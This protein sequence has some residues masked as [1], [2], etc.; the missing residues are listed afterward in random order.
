TEALI[1]DLPE[2]E[3]AM[4]AMPHGGGG[5]GGMGGGDFQ[6]GRPAPRQ[7]GGLRG[8]SPRR[9]SGVNACH[10]R[11]GRARPSVEPAGRSMRDS[12]DVR[13]DLLGG[14]L[15]V[16][17]LLEQE[18]EDDQS[19]ARHLDLAYPVDAFLGGAHQRDAVGE[20]AVP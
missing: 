11:L 8:H 18:V 16:Y 2:K 20:A 6:P 3:A 13:D 14:P 19:S 9:P 15:E 12:G 5:M 10:R 1:T 17:L 4:P 7:S